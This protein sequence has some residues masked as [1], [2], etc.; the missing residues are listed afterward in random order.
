M[1]RQEKREAL[2][3]RYTDKSRTA[4][5]ILAEAYHLR[6]E[7]RAPHRLTR[8]RRASLWLSTEIQC[9]RG[10]FYRQGNARTSSR[11][12]LYRRGPYFCELHWLDLQ[13]GD[14]KG[15]LFPLKGDLTLFCYPEKLLV[16][17]TLHATKDIAPFELTVRG[18]R[19]ISFQVLELAEGEKHQVSFSL[20]GEE[21]PLSKDALEVL[22][23]ETE[24]RYDEVRGCY[25]VGS[26]NPG[27]FEEHFYD[28]PNAYEGV[29]FRIHNAGRARK[30]T[31]CHQ[32]VRGAKGS[33]EGAVL[34][35]EEGH[36]LPITV[37]I[38][39]NFAGEKEEK[40][41]NPEDT[42]FSETYFP[43]YLDKGET[44]DV[45]SLHL[46]QN[47][48]RHMVK[49]FSSLGAWMDYFHSS[50][51]VTETTCY[52]PF[53][54]AG[55]PGVAI[56]D[57]RA[58]S[59]ESFWG[60]Q[61][62]HDNVAGHSFLS[63]KADGEWQ[64]MMYRGTTYHS[65]GP[66]WMDIEL[67]YLSGDGKI[68]ASVRTFELPQ[69]DEL[70]NFIGV[71][72]EVLDPVTVKEAGENLRLLR[73]TSRI[74]RLRYTHFHASDGFVKALD[75]SE[76]GLQVKGHPLL[77]Q[78]AFMALTGEAKGSN[79]VILRCWD[80]Q[81]R[82]SDLAPAASLWCEKD[83][84]TELFLTVDQEEVTLRPKDVLS[85]E[86][87]WL[88]FGKVHDSRVPAREA[89]VYGEK[90]PRVEQVLNGVK[91]SDFPTRLK[92]EDGKVECILSGGRD[93]IPVIVEN[94]PDYRRPQIYRKESIG[95][96]LLGQGRTGAWDGVQVFSQG[97][98]R[99]GA[100][101]LLHSDPTPQHVRIVLAK[102]REMRPK[103]QVTGLSLPSEGIQHVALIQAPWM[104]T[105]VQLRYPET[106]QTDG[107]DYIDHVR[108]D[109]P[110]RSPLSPLAEDWRQ[111]EGGSLWFQWEFE[112]HKAGGRISPNEDDVDL[113][114]WVRNQ[115]ASPLPVA[116]QFCSVLA[117]TIFEDRTLD[118]TWV[119][120]DGAW[121]R[122]KD[123]DRGGGKFELCHYPVMDGP[124]V[125]GAGD[126]G[127]SSE[128]TDANLVAATSKD[129]KYVF[130]VAWPRPRS[131]LS[132]AFI[133]CIHADPLLPDCP[134]GRRV[135]LRGK[136]YLMEGAL[137]DVLHR[138][139][140]E[141]LNP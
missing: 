39:K 70:R 125:H 97:P 52:V 130:A 33:V 88:P 131:I 78:G 105:P 36:P 27:G 7:L 100:V 31:V 1:Q 66:N 28:H 76:E 29:R 109:M 116:V 141:V 60:G 10:R 49:Q 83:R 120:I 62:Q 9:E 139:R 123:T 55:L 89:V 2:E 135:H 74:Q 47:W 67:H 118:R 26:F 90:A 68:R 110:A 20:F 82:S 112:K 19:K 103:I 25:L 63:Y 50:T 54:F 37:Q 113:E 43:L 16:S 75:F 140:R 108:E 124:D 138:V 96:R 104:E 56:A 94:L 132:N 101:F 71:R 106:L 5:E 92:A 53:K 98:G 84:D 40:F 35:D 115:A 102:E 87:V 44:V 21:A 14:D 8:A 95:W 99:F 122:M 38:S 13:W 61:P 58:M 72:Y 48:G 65:T 41:Y 51:G 69:K 129:G 45:T 136:L 111:G 126:W 114:F 17:L 85:F 18:K 30:I 46:Y 128:R 42:P 119:H 57:F 79:A 24:A 134:P 11:I 77:Q 93:L 117:G 64:Y 23:G 91:L 127:A 59:Q 32:T 121:K 3:V 4:F 137:E 15:R 12:N 22:E 6:G 107:L 34:L 80:A 73:I 81:V 86:A 133:P